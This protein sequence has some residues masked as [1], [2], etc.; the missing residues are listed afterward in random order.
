MQQ[1]QQQSSLAVIHPAQ[2]PTLLSADKSNILR[3]LHE[4]LAGYVPDASTQTGRDEIGSKA[5][6]VGTAKQDFVRLADALKAEHQAVIRSV[7]SELKIVETSCDELRDAIL[8]PRAAF[9]QIEK[10]RVARHEANIAE[11]VNAGSLAAQLGHEINIVSARERIA[12]IE[13]ERGLDWQEFSARA[14]AAINDAIAKTNDAIE[15]REKSDAE[16][17]EL[18]RLRAA[19]TERQRLEAIRLQAER[20]ERLKEEAAE[21]ARKA[22]E[23]QAAADA[24]A[25]KA[26]ADAQL[27]AQKATEEKAIKDAAEAADRAIKAEEARAAAVAKAEADA[28]AAHAR[29]EAE[30]LAAVE[31]ERKRAETAAKAEADALAKREAD[32]KHK[33]KIHNEALAAIAALGLSEES[34]RG[35]VVAIAGG[36]VPNVK[37]IY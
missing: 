19:E 6:K 30:K 34:A 1:T 10:D 33:A 12:E 27:A 3:R 5:K 18:S 17:A 13:A 24:A 8:A 7:N 29:A 22:A 25:A 14:T 9:L 23:A 31:A 37:I 26:E 2:V 35:I 28:K 4:E 11:I 36:K 16:Q 32:K 15:K 21:N 20:E